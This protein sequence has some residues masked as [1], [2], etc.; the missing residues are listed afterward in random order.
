MS[1]CGL[2]M[3]GCGTTPATSTADG[4]DTPR[5]SPTVHTPSAM[6]STPPGIPSPATSS[7]AGA[8]AFG[9]A[10]VR[11]F[12]FALSTRDATFLTDLVAP[13]TRCRGCADTEAEIERLREAGQYQLPGRVRILK[14]EVTGR[15]DPRVI[16]TAL[17]RVRPGTW[18]AEADGAGGVLAGQRRVRFTLLL[19]WDARREAWQLKDYNVSA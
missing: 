8:V 19:A 1:L 15:E 18:L 7:D 4:S 9:R 5:P 16:V 10:V 12:Y 11:T 13:R 17:V 3:T 2:V 6:P 14:A